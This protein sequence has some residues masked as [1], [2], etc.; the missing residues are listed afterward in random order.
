MLRIGM[1]FSTTSLIAL[2][3]LAGCG[4]AQKPGLTEL[5]RQSLA[6]GEAFGKAALDENWVAARRLT[7][8]KYQQTYKAAALRDGF[9]E[10]MSKH[11]QRV[12]LD[13]VSVS[14]AALPTGRRDAQDTFGMEDPPPATQWKALV[15]VGVGEKRNGA[16]EV[17]V[18]VDARLLLIDDGTGLKIADVAWRRR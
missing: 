11:E 1:R 14:L 3:L 10:A 12:D 17:T 7:T 4:G 2:L 9:L 13:A 16:E 5:E 8:E 6:L 15:Y 18:G